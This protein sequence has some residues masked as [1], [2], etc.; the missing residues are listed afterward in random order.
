MKSFT[1][2][3]LL[4]ATQ[5]AAPTAAEIDACKTKGTGCTYEICNTKTGT[6]WAANSWAKTSAT[7]TVKGFDACKDLI[8]DAANCENEGQNCSFDTCNKKT[9]DAAT[10]KTTWAPQTWS[11]TGS[12]KTPCEHH[13]THKAYCSNNAAWHDGAVS[14]TVAEQCS[15]ENCNTETKH[16]WSKDTMAVKEKQCDSW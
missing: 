12:A 15:F 11:S 1:L 7:A 5:A 2:M 14:K 3:A 10:K 6:T 16:V 9:T 8:G 13:I 4:G